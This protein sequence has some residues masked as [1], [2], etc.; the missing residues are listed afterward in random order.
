MFNKAIRMTA[1][2][3]IKQISDSNTYKNINLI[4]DVYN[5]LDFQG[6]ENKIKKTKVKT[7]LDE[8][9]LTGVCKIEST[10]C[11]LSVLDS[12]FFMGTMGAVV[13]EKICEAFEYAVRKNLPV[14]SFVASGGARMQ[15]GL[16][17][18]FQMSK[19]AGSVM[20]HSEKNLLYISVITDPTL[21]GVSASFASL[22]DIIL[23][24]AG[25]TYGFTGKRIIEDTINRKLSDTFQ[26]EMS[27]MRNGA[28]DMIVE[29][30][31]MKQIIGSIL[32]L[33]TNRRFYG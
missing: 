33:H 4:S 2:D 16:F 19:T 27:A 28:V 23:I 10:K 20:K 22:A 18:L 26:N 32:K 17:S 13:G 21:G 15:E 3:R 6:Y 24:E 14:V 25:T 31:E 11:V 9:V 1:E 8:A 30:N 5:P 29:R 7:G 12:H